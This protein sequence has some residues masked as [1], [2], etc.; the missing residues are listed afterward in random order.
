MKKLACF[1]AGRIGQVHATNAAA[2]LGVALIYLVDPVDT[3]ARTELAAH[4]GANITNT[5]TVFDD[6]SI[7]GILIAS[8]TNSHGDLLMRAAKAGKAVFCEKPISLD[9]ALTQQVMEAVEASGIPCMMGFQRRYDASFRAVH[10]RIASGMSGSLEQ[11]TMFSRDPSPPPRSYVETS[12]GMFRDSTIHDADM[13]RF[14]L[15]EEIATVYAVGACLIS[16]EIGVAGD[17]DTLMVTLTT[18]SGRMANITACRR[19]PMG[20]DQRL[21]ALCAR[22]VLNV[23]NQTQ[24]H[25]TVSSADGKRLA[26]PENYFIERFR[27]A[28]AAEMEAFVDLLENGKAPLAGI[29]DGYE[30]QRLVEAALQSYQTGVPVAFGA[31]WTPQGGAA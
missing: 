16:D 10:A 27:Q 22:E 14:L 30:A 3:P 23:E 7:D 1:G 24:T 28:Y 21:E 4:T 12:G 11:L 20:Y 13:A 31:D 6:P 9:F 18:V 5:D 19:G 2:Q 15:A 26:A 8:S 17:V 25:M 29:R